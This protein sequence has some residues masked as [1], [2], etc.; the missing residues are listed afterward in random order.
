MILRSS[1]QDLRA[2][3]DGIRH[4]RS[5][6]R[7]GDQDH[8]SV[9]FRT[10]HSSVSQRYGRRAGSRLEQ[11][12]NLQVVGELWQQTLAVD[13]TRDPS[14]PSSHGVACMRSAAV[15]LLVEA[16]LNLR[17]LA[18]L[19]GVVNGK[20]SRVHHTQSRVGNMESIPVRASLIDHHRVPRPSHS[21][22]ATSAP[23]SATV[24]VGARGLA[25]TRL[26]LGLNG[27]PPK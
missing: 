12:L 21:L 9:E 18:D 3:I 16:R 11:R 4:P 2:K 6:R 5:H 23:R 13:A 24:N 7:P 8:R 10:L 20:P 15:G 1:P 14:V 27:S 17:L 22:F 26:I 19:P 25:L